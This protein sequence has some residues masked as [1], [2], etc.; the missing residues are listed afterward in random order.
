MDFPNHSFWFKSASALIFSSNLARLA[1]NF[2]IAGV[3]YSSPGNWSD[4][5]YVLSPVFLSTNSETPQVII[6]GVAI[7]VALLVTAFKIPM[8]FPPEALTLGLEYLT[9]LEGLKV[10][11]EII[12]LG[13]ELEDLVEAELVEADIVLTAGWFVCLATIVRCYIYYTFIVK[14]IFRLGKI[15]VFLKCVIHKSE[16]KNQ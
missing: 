11:P 13:V 7:K 5:L 3:L 9:S 14:S 16:I 10:S 12:S 4:I 2:A 8:L 1:R 15:D 6:R